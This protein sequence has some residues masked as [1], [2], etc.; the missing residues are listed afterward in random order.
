[1]GFG[2]ISMKEHFHVSVRGVQQEVRR[3]RNTRGRECKLRHPVKD[4]VLPVRLSGAELH[5]EVYTAIY[6]CN[7]E[8]I[9]MKSRCSFGVEVAGSSLVSI[10]RV[11]HR[12]W[13][14]SVWLR[15]MPNRNQ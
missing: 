2:P 13:K 6:G 4:R 8:I 7:L 10:S 1:M 12:K 15:T 3:D 11:S 9:T 14:D 5:W